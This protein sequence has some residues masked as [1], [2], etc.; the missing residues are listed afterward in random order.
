M[1]LFGLRKKK[2]VK[3]AKD[4][5]KELEKE[6]RYLEKKMPEA[7]RMPEKIQTGVEKTAEQK[8]SAE[9]A[10]L[11]VR[12]NKYN[13]ILST[14]NYLKT[15]INAVKSSISILKE[16][17]KLREENLKMVETAVNKVE[18]RLLTLD[19][20]FMRPSG[21]VEDV[22]E[23]QNVESVELTLGDLKNQINQLKAQID[24]LA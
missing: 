22:G 19:S 21:F 12:I 15:T 2:E 6:E 1:A 10:P 17:D 7:E 14:M 24:T 13:Q 3:E 8:P 16:L 5:I 11:F 4:I 9:F 18:Q 23:L 20:S